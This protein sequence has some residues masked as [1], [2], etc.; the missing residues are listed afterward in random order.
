MH[1]GNMFLHKSIECGHSIANPDKRFVDRFFKKISGYDQHGKGARQIS[2]SF[3]STTNITIRTEIIESRSAIMG[4]S[5][6]E[7]ISL[8]DS[9][10]LMVRVVRV[11]MG[12]LSNCE[13]FKPKNLIIH[14]HPHIFYN[15]LSEPGRDIRKIKPDNAFRQQQNNLDDGNCNHHL[16]EMVMAF[17][18]GRANCLPF[19]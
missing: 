16:K 11:P 1:A 5:P 13:R 17:S 14:L 2:E 3:Q 10:S 12:V 19:T 18:A 15:T 8:I 9:I 7:K 6:S 4:I